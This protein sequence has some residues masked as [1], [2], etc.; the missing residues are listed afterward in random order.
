[1]VG[2]VGGGPMMGQGHCWGHHGEILQGSFTGIGQG[3][4][5]LPIASRGSWARFTV[6]RH[7]PASVEPPATD[8]YEGQSRGLS[9][10]R[11]SSWRSKTAAAAHLALEHIAAYRPEVATWTG[12]L[13]VGSSLP[14]G[15]GMG[16][17]TS[18]IVAAIRAIA[19]AAGI[20]L[21]P[22][23]IGRIAV[24]AE[25]ASDPHGEALPVLY[26]QRRGHVVRRWDRPLPPLVL[27]G[28]R[29]G[30]PVDTVGTPPLEA[31]TEYDE[32]HTRL[33]VAILRSDARAIGEVATRSAE[34]NQARVPKQRFGE[35]VE[36]CADCGG[37]GVQVAHSG[38]VGGILVD[39]TA[40]G[41][42]AQ[43]ARCRAALNHAGFPKTVDELV[44]SMAQ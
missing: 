16:S 3:L 6:D 2:M 25:G 13:E 31:D 14:P 24:R 26:A 5:S 32:L 8:C 27:V 43:W 33:D 12:S 40:P 29:C 7:S 18:D 28:C 39:A 15:W 20:T 1:G 21:P 37:V 42:A 9:R 38:A 41:A 36:I 23:A 44:G 30:Q 10:I 17:S 22:E 19:N 34:L 35:L 11:C 4:V